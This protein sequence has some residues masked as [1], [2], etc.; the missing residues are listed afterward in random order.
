L[1]LTP[2]QLE[3]VKQAEAQFLVK[4]KLALPPDRSVEIE[5]KG[6]R[7]WLMTIWPFWFKEEFSEEQERYWIQWWEV[8]Q[9]M[10]RGE[11]VPASDAVI[12]LPWGRGLGKS[13][14]I[15][16][17]R[18]MRGAILK[19]GYSLMISE[20]DDQATEHLGNCRIL[21][22]H[23]ESRLLEFYPNM[24]V[25]D[26]AD[27]L[28]GMPTAD[29]KEM[30]I[31]KNGYILRA[32]GLSAKMRGLRVG[33]HRPS[34]ICLDDIDDVNDSLALSLNKLRL[35]TA[36]IFPVQSREN[37]SIS[38]GQNVIGEHSVMNQILQGKTDAL[39]DRTVI[40]P[41]KAF[42]HLEIHSEIDEIGK[43]RHAILPSSIPSWQGL[44]INAAQ[45]FLNNSGLETFRAEYQ[46]EFDQF[47]A[48]KVIPEY[49]ED[50][51]IVTWDEFQAVFGERRIPMA[52]KCKAGLDVGYSEGQY[53]HYSTWDFI[54]TSGM[55]SRFPGL[56]FLYRSCSFSGTSIDDQATAVKSQMWPNEDVET[57]QMS[58]ERTGEMLTLQQKY[59]IPFAKFQY[60]KPEDGVAQWRHLSKPDKSKP[61]PFRP[62]EKID[63][64]YKL[65]RPSLFYIVDADQRRVARDDRGLRLFR[66][67][68]STW[69]YVPVKITEAGQTV[70]KPSKINDDHCDTFKGTIALFGAL[71][72]EK[73]VQEVAEERFKAATVFARD[74]FK[75][76]HSIGA[77]MSRSI[78]QGRVLKQLKEEGL[79]FDDDVAYSGIDY[80]G[81]Y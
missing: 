2:E 47:K 4:E 45:T 69:E 50:L 35:I 62:D 67:Q 51:Q 9:R 53:P 64:V 16:A 28:K 68:V 63:G 43:M 5:K 57:W 79:D 19:G 76:D 46:N 29:R 61:H 55:S 17:G 74:E 21:I 77:Q 41:S 32:K 12:L 56:K 37:A 18:I 39:A 11:F 31:C 80:T 54:A 20:T 81:G 27:A 42:T 25:A 71:P 58:H 73:S 23:P 66:E 34:D 3:L 49:N 8:L 70:Q 36:S 30:F 72:A 33:I 6:W 78:A 26:N 14:T 7:E 48:G 38:F 1:E 13:A 75:D 22:E 10:R 60:Y 52:W 24:A 59:D 40:G 44:N 65:G 15:E